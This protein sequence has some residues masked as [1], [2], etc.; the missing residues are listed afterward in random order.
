M[1]APYSMDLRNRVVTAI[2]AGLSCR[3]AAA[4]FSVGV[5][6]AIRWAKRA[7]ETG[8]AAAQ[9]M[10]GR[11]PFALAKEAGWLRA[12]F[13]EK[14]DITLRELLFELHERGIDVSY[15]G[16]WH[17]ADRLG[18]SFKK[19]PACRRAGPS[20]HRPPPRAVAAPSSER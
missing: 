12:R 6:T 3:A 5:S 1:G 14:P 7:S 11:R 4:R 10:G 16:V 15:Y 17:M 18:L 19:K 9:P 20:V 8:S 13:A 2:A